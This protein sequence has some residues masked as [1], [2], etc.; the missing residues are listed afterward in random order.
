LA[1]AALICAIAAYAPREVVRTALREALIRGEQTAKQLQTLRSFYSDQ[2]VAKATKAGVV[3][4]PAYRADS[5]TIPVP[6]TFILDVA[7][8]FR[9]NGFIVRLVSPYPWPGRKDRVLD[10]FQTEAWEQLKLNPGGIW[11]RQEQLDGREVL[12]VAV[13][14]S[15]QASCV[16]C[17]NSHPSSPKKDWKL[18]DVRGLIEVVQPME[19]V[20]AGS[21]GLSWKLVAGGSVAGLVLLGLL[22]AIGM[23]LMAPLRDLTRTIHAMAQGQQSVQIPHTIRLDEFGTVAC[24]LENLKEQTEERARAEALVSHMARH[25]ALTLLPNRLLFRENLERDL[26]RVHRGGPS[27]CCV[28]TWTISKLS[29][30]HLA[31]PLVT[32]Y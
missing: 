21:R 12:R 18:G 4:S 13:A 16:T 20:L 24:A 8:K 28:S 32:P 14:D 25:D 23:R 15:M 27:P 6:T 7:E 1:V 19:K 9:E 11:S 26:S 2:V 10:D 30:T 29:M 3:A 31:T 22:L 17:H 5:T